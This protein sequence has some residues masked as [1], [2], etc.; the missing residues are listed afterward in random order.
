M[1]LFTKQNL[2]GVGVVV[3]GTLI[4]RYAL[5]KYAEWKARKAIQDPQTGAPP[6]SGTSA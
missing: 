6:I 2:I 1:K 4:A 5:A 3:A